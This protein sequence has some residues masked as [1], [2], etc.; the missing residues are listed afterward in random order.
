MKKVVVKYKLKNHDDFE[1]KMNEVDVDFGS[2]YWQHDRIYVPKNYKPGANFPRLV[3]RT[4]MKAIDRPARYELI[5]KRHIV[6]SGADIVDATVVRD[7][8]EAVNIIQQLGFKQLAEVSKKRRSSSIGETMIY[9]DSVDGVP[10]YYIKMEAPIKE[11]DKI[12]SLRTDL[13]ETL[14]SIDDQNTRV[15]EPYFVT[16]NDNFD[17]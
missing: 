10:G 11:N 15:E 3:M 1:T 8:V 6:D 17:K 14:E 13:V 5:L 12:D 2:M 4:E 7:Y 16:L 9:L